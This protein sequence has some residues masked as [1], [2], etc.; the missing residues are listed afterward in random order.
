MRLRV[1][2]QVH[3]CCGSGC[4]LCLVLV[5][6]Q[7]TLPD[8]SMVLAFVAWLVNA[9]VMRLAPFAPCYAQTS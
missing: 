8:P 1:L 9:A 4:A 3:P 6:V 5:G 2:A 7:T